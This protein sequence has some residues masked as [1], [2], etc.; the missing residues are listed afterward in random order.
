[1]EAVRIYV[2]RA[3]SICGMFLYVLQCKNLSLKF[4]GTAANAR[5]V[6]S[7]VDIIDGAGSEINYWLPLLT[8]AAY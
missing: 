6:A 1:M 8:I 4:Q 5:D 2:W 7:M 3:A